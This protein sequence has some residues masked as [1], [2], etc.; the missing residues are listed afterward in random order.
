ML[1]R[2]LHNKSD[3]VLIKHPALL[4][5]RDFLNNLLAGTYGIDIEI[6]P[7]CS[8]L[9]TDF[10]FG[11]EDANGGIEKKMVKDPGIPEILTRSMDTVQTRLGT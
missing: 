2:Y 9:I 11:K 4:K 8:N 1:R 5:S 10:E 7:S 6:N 3:R